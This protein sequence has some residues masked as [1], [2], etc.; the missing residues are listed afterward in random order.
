MSI[1]YA[2]VSKEVSKLVGKQFDSM[3][4]INYTLAVLLG[5]E[6]KFFKDHEWIIPE[7]DN[8]KVR[9]L[10]ET[11]WISLTDGNKISFKI[12]V[13]ISFYG[14]LEITSA[15]LYNDKEIENASSLIMK[16]IGQ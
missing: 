4:E 9:T 5:F 2:G 11:Y 6:I 1:T 3:N 15:Q 10:F 16:S 13:S 14:L 8:D 7:N 12:V